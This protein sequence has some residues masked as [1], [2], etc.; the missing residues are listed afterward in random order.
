MPATLTQ[1]R[2]RC[3][4]CGRMKP[5]NQF[6]V[7]NGICLECFDR[8]Y[9][10]CEECGEIL[11]RERPSFGQY[12]RCHR[13]NGQNLC[14]RCYYHLSDSG[15]YGVDRWRPKAFDVSFATYNRIGSK[16]KYGVE[17]ETTDCANF[18][19]L[20]GQTNFGCKADCSVSGME[21]DSPILY[22]DEGLDYIADFLA[23]GEDNG[24]YAESECGCHTHYDMRDMNDDQL[25]SVAYAY[26][27]SLSLWEALVPDHRRDGTYSHTPH[28]TCAD[29]RDEY[30]Y[31]G[32][33]FGETIDRLDCERYEMVNLTAYHDHKT[34]EVRMLEGTCDAETICNW[35]TLHC[36]FADAVKD[37][38]FEEIDARFSGSRHRQFE[39]LSDMLHDDGLIG[40]M[41]RRARQ[42]GRPV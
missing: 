28:W 7:A 27:K 10:F 40:W 22:G 34:F 42:N 26:R 1:E 15:R 14:R 20:Y 25:A 16:R 8:S 4:D 39:V 32:G 35:I 13:Y 17:I 24:W 6:S 30:N 41:K 21:F 11:R 31:V 36:R 33:D 38:S 29:F 37:L 3:V 18:R 23:F 19:D 5:R 9:C 2:R 12:D